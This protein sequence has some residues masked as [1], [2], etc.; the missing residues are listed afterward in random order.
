[1]KNIYIYFDES[2]YPKNN[3]KYV[4]VGCVAYDGACKKNIIHK[5]VYKLNKIF[6]NKQ[7]IKFSNIQNEKIRD[8][9][10]DKIKKD[11]IFYFSKES[12]LLKNSDIHDVLTGLVIYSIERLCKSIQ[13]SSLKI[14][15]DKS[16]YKIN[17][18]KI[19][20]SFDFVSS[21]DMQDSIRSNGVQHADW[22]AGERGDLS[23]KHK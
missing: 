1:M 12:I 14:I 19:I 10:L 3:K 17:I 13:I 15:Y 9:I 18:N 7:E 16:S 5:E 23:K 8:K 2:I 6:K 20:S 21:F 4:A 22:I 11:S